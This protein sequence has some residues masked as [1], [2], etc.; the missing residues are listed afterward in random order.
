MHKGYSNAGATAN[1]CAANTC[2]C[3]SSPPIL[4]KATAC[5]NRKA[6]IRKAIPRAPTYPC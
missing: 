1:T 5:R 4:L 6:A 3:D 2:A